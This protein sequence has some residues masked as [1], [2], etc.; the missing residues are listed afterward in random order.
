MTNKSSMIPEGIRKANSTFPLPNLPLTLPIKH[1]SE[2]LSVGQ[3][4]KVKVIGV[5]TVK[6][7]INLSIKQASG[8]VS[9]AP[10]GGAQREKTDD[11]QNNRN[12]KGGNRPDN[13]N[14]NRN[15]RPRRE[16]KS[17][18]DMLAALKNKFN[19]H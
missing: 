10:K 16:E 5:D 15:D 3:V 4:V 9:T 13:R 19:K 17:L 18:D 8:Y 1:P 6:Q 2:A 14:G 11:R 12:F 7:R